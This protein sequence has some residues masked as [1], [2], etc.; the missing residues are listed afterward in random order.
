MD[1]ISI[2]ITKLTDQTEH[3]WFVS[4]QI[5]SYRNVITFCECKG[6]RGLLKQ[7]LIFL[8]NADA[9]SINVIIKCIKILLTKKII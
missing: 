9:R 3:L 6:L 8:G 2:L 1:L 7:E 4:C 5:V